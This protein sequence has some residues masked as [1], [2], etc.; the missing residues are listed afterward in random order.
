MS[1]E[2]HPVIDSGQQQSVF[3]SRLPIE[4]RRIIYR[5]VWLGEVVH[6]CC[7]DRSP[8]GDPEKQDN[9][10]VSVPCI[11]Q[12]DFA[13][14][15]HDSYTETDSAWGLGHQACLRSFKEKFP[16]T[17]SRLMDPKKPQESSWIKRLR[18]AEGAKIDNTMT[19]A[20]KDKHR[21]QRGVL[22][23]LLTCHQML[24]IQYLDRLYH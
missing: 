24:V 16:C 6:I 1:R 11:G 13:Q 22:S 3:F 18:R 5:E 17:I 9:T 19:V 2:N 12:H 8:Y 7:K 21:N 20:G 23:M 10:L 4:L 15:E 14:W